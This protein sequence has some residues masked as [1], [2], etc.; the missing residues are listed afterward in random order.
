[1]FWSVK[2]TILHA[3]NDNFKPVVGAQ[4]R[5]VWQAW[6]ILAIKGI[7]M[8]VRGR[9]VSESVN[10][11]NIHEKILFQIVLNEVLKSCEK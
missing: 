8:G 11:R 5:N 4:T 10:K 7:G 1:M 3:K 6:Q 9:E 2:S